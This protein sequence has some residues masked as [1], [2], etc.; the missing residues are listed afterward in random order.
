M[1]FA[2]HL[3]LSK[4]LFTFIR[5]HLFN[6]YFLHQQIVFLVSEPKMACLQGNKWIY[7][8]HSYITSTMEVSKNVCGKNFELLEQ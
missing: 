5:L 1:Y 8:S 6:C 4:E 7:V 3:K 2:Q